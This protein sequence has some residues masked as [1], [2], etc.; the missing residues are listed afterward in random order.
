MKK[1]IKF[2]EVVNLDVT[3]ARFILPRLIK[4]KEESMGYPYP[5][6]TME[7]YYIVLDKMIKAFSLILDFERNETKEEDKIIKEG[8]KL[9][10]EHFTSLWI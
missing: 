5:F 9:F 6:Q 4:F 3:L 7:E 2:K 10:A 1:K 8:L